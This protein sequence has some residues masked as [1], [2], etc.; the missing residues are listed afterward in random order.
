[1]AKLGTVR[2][3]Q[4]LCRDDYG[5]FA[6]CPQSKKRIERGTRGRGMNNAHK[7]K[8]PCRTADGQFTTCTK[9]GARKRRRR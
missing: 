8:A 6:S 1:M 2:I 9:R 5:K 3:T 7:R 4:R